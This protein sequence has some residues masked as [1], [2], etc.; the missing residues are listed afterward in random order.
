MDNEARILLDDVIEFCRRDERE[1]RLIHMLEQC[2]AVAF[3]DESLTV[4]VPSR[5]AYTYLVK[6]RESIEAYL[7]EDLLHAHEA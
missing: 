2:Q 3:D 5:F 6:Q 4:Q 1:P 7:E